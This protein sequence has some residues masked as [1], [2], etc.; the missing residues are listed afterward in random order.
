VSY[1]FVRK[2]DL[3]QAR[4]IIVAGD[5]L[6]LFHYNDYATNT[7]ADETNSRIVLYGKLLAARRGFI[8][9]DIP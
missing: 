1:R 3:E 4:I 2:I 5:R 9:H 7:I 6:L 8:Q